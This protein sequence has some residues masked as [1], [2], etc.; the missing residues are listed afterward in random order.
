MDIEERDLRMATRPDRSLTTE[1]MIWLSEVIGPF[2]KAVVSLQFHV[3]G[4]DGVRYVSIH[5]DGGRII[6]W[7][8]ET[9]SM[10]FAG[11]KEGVS[12]KKEAIGL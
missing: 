12:Y 11:M 3:A 6:A 4:V 5:G 7:V 8:P 1:E 10:Q 2:R 9:L